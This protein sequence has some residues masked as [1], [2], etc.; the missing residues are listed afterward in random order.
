[1]RDV[2]DLI[3]MTEAARILGCHRSSVYHMAKM[4]RLDAVDV[5]GRLLVSRSDIEAMP[6]VRRGRPPKEGA[7]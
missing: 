5:A 4:G 6:P 1:M 3:S 2:S 7:A